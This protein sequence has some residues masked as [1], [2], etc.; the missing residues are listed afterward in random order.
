MIKEL[1]TQELA[2]FLGI[3]RQALKK[4]IDNGNL[5]GR[6]LDMNYNLIKSEKQGR[7]VIY[8]LEEIVIVPKETWEELAAEEFPTIRKIRELGIHAKER[9]INRTETKSEITNKTGVSRQTAD[10]WDGLLV[11]KGYMRDGGYTYYEIKNRRLN[12]ITYAEYQ[13]Y[14]SSRSKTRALVRTLTEAE[15]EHGK[16]LMLENI[17]TALQDSYCIRVRSYLVNEFTEKYQRI[18]ATL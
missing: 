5:S 4:L 2:N 11:E 16:E 8:S 12:Q 1:T 13:K 17:T 18:A 15:S 10:R 7:K 9:L 3:S 14:W 6:L